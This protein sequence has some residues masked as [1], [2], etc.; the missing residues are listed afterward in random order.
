M[1]WTHLRHDLV[2]PGLVVLGVSF[3][4]LHRCVV[5]LRLR[6]DVE[7]A[8]GQQGAQVL[9]RHAREVL[10]LHH[11][12][13]VLAGVAVGHVHQ[14]HA[15]VALGEGTHRQAVGGVKVGFHVLTA[16]SRHQLHLQM[17]HENEEIF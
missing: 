7:L 15:V 4:P 1:E 16:G 6:V 2:Q 8:G 5:H 11:L 10:A 3:Q 13:E 14:V 17:R 12:G 9:G